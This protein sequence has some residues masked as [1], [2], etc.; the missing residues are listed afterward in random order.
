MRTS[1]I[2]KKLLA[3]LDEFPELPDMNSLD[4]EFRLGADYVP[5]VQ[6]FKEKLRAIA[7]A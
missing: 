5:A 1:T 6:A 7:G 4:F 2:R 3:L